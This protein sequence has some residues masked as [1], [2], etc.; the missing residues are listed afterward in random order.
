MTQFQKV[1]LKVRNQPFDVFEVTRMDDGRKVRIGPETGFFAEKLGLNLGSSIQTDG[2]TFI[3]N[4]TI[5]QLKEFSAYKSPAMQGPA[6][7]IGFDQIL[8]K[9]G[10]TK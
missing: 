4:E 10:V 3:I 7:E 8:D 5:D 6:Q 1:K 9:A 2:P